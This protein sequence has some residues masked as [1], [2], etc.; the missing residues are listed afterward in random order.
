MPSHGLGRPVNENITA[1]TQTHAGGTGDIHFIGVGNADR[2]VK[3]AVRISPVDDI[4]TLG[5]FPVT[6]ELLVPLG[7]KSEVNIKRPKDASVMQQVHL[8]VTF[9]DDHPGHFRP[10]VG[11]EFGSTARSQRHEEHGANKTSDYLHRT[12]PV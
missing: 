3:A 4:F 12:L 5:R 6:L 2:Q 11:P 1:R 9:I 8:S 7:R 10:I